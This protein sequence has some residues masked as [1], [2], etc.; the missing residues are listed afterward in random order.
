MP[1]LIPGFNCA[2]YN[3]SLFFRLLWTALN[4]GFFLQKV[5]VNRIWENFCCK[6]ATAR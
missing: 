2:T 6:S 4:E 1:V 3:V 5:K